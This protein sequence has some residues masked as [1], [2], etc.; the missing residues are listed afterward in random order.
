MLEKR[1]KL[2]FFLVFKGYQ[3]G[4]VCVILFLINPMGKGMQKNHEES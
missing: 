4:K 2:C 1:K 3:T